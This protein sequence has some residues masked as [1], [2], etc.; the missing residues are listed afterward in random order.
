[1][2][3]KKGSTETRADLAAL[4]EGGKSLIVYFGACLTDGQVYASPL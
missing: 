2:L 3:T 4:L 1:M